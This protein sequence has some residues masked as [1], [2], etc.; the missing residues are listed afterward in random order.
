MTAAG[1]VDGK[2]MSDV[3]R[4]AQI[5]TNARGTLATLTRR[6][7]PAGRS[8]AW[9]A[10]TW[11]AAYAAAALAVIVCAMLC[12]DTPLLGLEQRLPHAFVQA[13]EYITDLGLSGWFL[14]PTGILLL[15]MAITDSPE[16]PRIMRGVMAA[17]AVR[18]GFVFIA[19]AVPGLFVAIVKRLIGR[20][21]PWAPNHDI[22]T[23]TPFGWHVDYASFPSGHATTAFSAAVAIGAI[24]P[25]ARPYLWIYA[26]IIACSRVIVSAHHPSDVVAGAI[27][28]SFGA[29]LV[30]N[31]FAARRLGFE[32]A[33]NGCVQSLPG[34]SWRR[35]KAV[36][37]GLFAA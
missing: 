14:W 7:R 36:A 34:P 5:A 17:I 29:V 18:F 31:W 26:V 13:F 12:L 2:A 16:M 1:G 33:S 22:W 20:E 30:R 8:I 24:W 32:V 4:L 6:P 15:A 27:V 37:R 35:V 9:P 23:F 3:S 28:G 10:T 19:I 25:R 21:R 11:M